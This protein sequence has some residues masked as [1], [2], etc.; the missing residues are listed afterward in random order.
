MTYFETRYLGVKMTK[1]STF[2]P[3]KYLGTIN[4]E[5]MYLGAIMTNISTLSVV[6]INSTIH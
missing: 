6:T 1:K 3:S 5:I 4:F 2:Y